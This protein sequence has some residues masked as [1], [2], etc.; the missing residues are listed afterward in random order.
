M[1]GAII[2]NPYR[3]P[4]E[5]VYQAERLKEEFEILGIETEIIDDGYLRTEISDGKLS[6]SLLSYNFAVYLDKDKY[7]SLILEKLGL[8]LFNSHDAV[9][10]CD[11]KGQTYIALSSSGVNLPKTIFGALCYNDS[12]EINKD[13]ADK[14]IFNLGLPLIVKES[15]G[16]MGKGVY[17]VNTKKELL[18]VMKVVKLKPHLFQEYLPYKK[19]VDVR[20]IV[21]GGKVVASMERSNDSDFR[22]NMARGGCGRKID[23]PIEFKKTAEK[24]AKIL[25]L[26][27]CGVDLL[28]GKNG[29][30]V[31]CEVNSNAFI[32][33]IEST[34]G[35]NVA[36][37]YVEHILS[38]IV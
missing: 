30:P 21:I 34:T 38:K 26:D 16:S 18:S 11:D 4:N 24:V 32:G 3:I 22:S 8:K 9:R 25:S 33:G 36:K 37:L 2:I 17:L 5:S 14:I 20:V 19:G 27:Y 1:K 12:C 13:V 23:L 15:Y 35:V 10:L 31:V 29:E 28:Y 6:S 7:L